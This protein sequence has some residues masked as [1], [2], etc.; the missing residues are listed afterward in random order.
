VFYDQTIP[1]PLSVRLDMLVN[2]SLG[3][4]SECTKKKEGAF[5]ADQYI[6]AFC[7]RWC[8]LLH[9]C[10][11]LSDE[12]APESNKN[13]ASMGGDSVEIPFTSFLVTSGFCKPMAPL[14]SPRGLPD[15]S[16]RPLLMLSGL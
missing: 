1:E 15:R 8:R 14:R 6:R 16:N 4:G 3:S 10:V 2:P 7:G 9:E 5:I 11:L 12:H 13:A